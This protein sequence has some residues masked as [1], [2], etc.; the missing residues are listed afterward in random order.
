VEE[1]GAG[2]QERAEALLPGLYADLRA[3]AARLLKG[4]RANH[5]LSP[6]ALVHEA[7]VRLSGG[8]GADIKDEVHFAALAATAMRRALVDHARARR[9]AKRRP[10]DGMVRLD[11]G[12]SLTPRERAEP[13]DVL[14]LH[15]ALEELA[16]LHARQARLVE[17]RFFGGLSTAQA[18]G[19]LGI[20][21]ATAESDWR[22][23]RTWL[24]REL[25]K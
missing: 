14:A 23:A 17:L 1:P 6:T 13:V 9:A 24:H 19:A 22:M 25:S 10:G 15:G 16:T 21:L 20:S 4:E 8:G 12:A 7:Y 3:Q 11:S 18:A 2:K 5:T